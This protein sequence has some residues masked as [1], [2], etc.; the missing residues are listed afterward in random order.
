MS[1]SYIPNEK[2]LVKSLLLNR[3][4]GV[5]YQPFMDVKNLNVIAYEALARFEGMTPDVF[6]GICHKDVDLFFMAEK[7][8]KKIQFAQRPKNKKL[9]VNFDPHILQKKERVNEVFDFFSN[10]EN[11]VIELVENSVEAVNAPKLL[12]VFKNLKYDFAVDDFLK[13]NSIL[14]IFLL[15][16]CQ[17]LKLDKDILSYMLREKS[18]LHVSRG[19]V[20][21]AH[22]LGKKV[23]LEGIETQKDLSLAQEIGVDY[24]QGF[25]FRSEF[26][27]IR[28]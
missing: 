16:E 26:K 9:F 27:N 22:E 6:F 18:F 5:E 2:E 21:Y 28:C 12:D 3:A 17:Y 11:F 4:Y 1:K 25:L 7:V 8:L 13:E 23:V 24:V 14:S 20:Q 15:S 10:Q 19:L